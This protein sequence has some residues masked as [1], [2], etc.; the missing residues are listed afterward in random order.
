MQTKRGN[1]VKEANALKVLKKDKLLILPN[2]PQPKKPK[3]PRPSRKKVLNL[4]PLKALKGSSNLKL[5][6]GDPL[7]P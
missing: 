5:L 1:R 7:L 4:G 2:S 6:P 3:H